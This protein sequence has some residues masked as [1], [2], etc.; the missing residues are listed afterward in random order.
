MVRGRGPGGGSRGL[1]ATQ[2]DRRFA[3]EPRRCTSKGP[4]VFTV[5]RPAAQP[6]VT[7][8]GVPKMAHLSQPQKCLTQAPDGAEKQLDGWCGGRRTGH[9]QF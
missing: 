4:R 3:L 1:A 7:Q 6:E 9:Y 2:G 5:A 8:K